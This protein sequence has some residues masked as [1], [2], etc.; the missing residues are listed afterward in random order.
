LLEDAVLCIPGDVDGGCTKSTSGFFGLI[1]KEL[2]VT[3]NVPG[4]LIR[5][6]AAMIRWSSGDA[7]MWDA[8]NSSTNV[9]TSDPL[10]M[11]DRVISDPLLLALATELLG[12]E[13]LLV[14]TVD[15]VASRV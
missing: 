4:W 7:R 3:G 1:G 9:S 14:E 15:S 8:A 10:E 13:S 5:S 11:T 12:T 6:S 2:S